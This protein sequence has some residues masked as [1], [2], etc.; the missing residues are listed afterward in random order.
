MELRKNRKQ[1]PCYWENQ[2]GGCRKKHCPFQHKNPE[3]RTDGIAPS[4]PQSPQQAL[5]AGPQA[6]VPRD[7]GEGSPIVLPHELIWQQQQRQDS[8]IL[9]VLP[10]TG[11][12]LG[13]PVAGQRRVMAPH[14]LH[15]A[16][17]PPAYAALP[18]DSLVVNFEEGMRL[19]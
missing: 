16:P 11:D 2:P 18:V 3:A 12:M 6:A 14:A 17:A 7:A 10:A 19:Y 5:P 13:H 15:D 4:Q 1:I 9:G 8:A